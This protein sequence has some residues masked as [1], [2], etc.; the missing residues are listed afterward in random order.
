MCIAP[1]QLQAMVLRYIGIFTFTVICI[2][3]CFL[4]QTQCSQN[5]LPHNVHKY[6][7]ETFVWFFYVQCVKKFLHHVCKYSIC[8]V[9]VAL[10]I[11]SCRSW[12]L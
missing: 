3:L 6:V 2:F 9:N 5:S 4:Q 7:Q 1:I 8:V 12:C 11:M 10:F